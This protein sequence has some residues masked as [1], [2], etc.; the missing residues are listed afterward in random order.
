[1]ALMAAAGYTQSHRNPGIM[2]FA[3]DF[4][5]NGTQKRAFYLIVAFHLDHQHLEK[6]K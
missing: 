4:T 6:E 5:S 2:R 3:I 1:M